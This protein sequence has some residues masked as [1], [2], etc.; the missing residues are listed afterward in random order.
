MFNHPIPYKASTHKD[1]KQMKP[2]SQKRQNNTKRLQQINNKQLTK[3]DNVLEEVNDPE[4]ILLHSPPST[5]N[6]IKND[7]FELPIIIPQPKRNSLPLNPK[8]QKLKKKIN[9]TSFMTDV[10]LVKT[11]PLPQEPSP[12]VEDINNQIDNMIHNIN[13][14]QTD[15]KQQLQRDDKGKEFKELLDDIDSYR[16]IVQEEFDEV[17]YL[18]QF[19]DRTH[20]LI[21]RHKNVMTNIFKKA[22]LRPRGTV[23]EEE[24]NKKERKR[25]SK[26]E[27]KYWEGDDDDDYH[28]D[29]EPYVRNGYYYRKVRKDDTGDLN[30]VF[31]KL[32]KINQVKENLTHIQD[33]C[34]GYHY[35]LKKKIE[36]KHKHC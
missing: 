1:K 11:K 33:D 25:K 31:N 30:E 2:Q 19:A 26:K 20:K 18:I 5:L 4:P 24:G 12:I 13:E 21:D 23:D 28:N 29:N 3:L 6:E 10:G 32:K 36:E 15:K 14:I 35:N 27:S 9:K 7:N 16:N 17:K 8:E 34:L 22:G